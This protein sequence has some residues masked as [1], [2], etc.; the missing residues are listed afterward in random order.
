VKRVVASVDDRDR[1]E[2]RAGRYHFVETRN[3]NAFL[4]RIE[5]TGSRAAGDRCTELTLALDCLAKQ[6]PARSRR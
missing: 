5:R 3:V 4:M 1:C 6:P 2:S